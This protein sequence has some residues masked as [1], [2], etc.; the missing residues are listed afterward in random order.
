MQS[1]VTVRKTLVLKLR[2]MVVKVVIVD[3]TRQKTCGDTKWIGRPAECLSTWDVCC[4]AARCS[5]Y[6]AVL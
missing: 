4:E 2:E 1:D 5:Q 6:T 3:V